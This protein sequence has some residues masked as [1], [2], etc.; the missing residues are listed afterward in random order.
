M[1]FSNTTGLASVISS[2]GTAGPSVFISDAVLL[3]RRWWLGACVTWRYKVGRTSDDLRHI[4]V[5][6]IPRS[7]HKLGVQVLLPGLYRSGQ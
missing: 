3:A 1:M 7:K 2:S 5:A 6:Q 4:R